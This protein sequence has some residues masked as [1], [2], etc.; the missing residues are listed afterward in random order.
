MEYMEKDLVLELLFHQFQKNNTI[1]LEL[2]TGDNHIVYTR[3]EGDSPKFFTNIA[4]VEVNLS[5]LSSE[6]TP[7]QESLLHNSTIIVYAEDNKRKE[8]L[9]DEELTFSPAYYKMYVELEKLFPEYTIEY[10][11][12]EVYQSLRFPYSWSVY[13][14]G[15]STRVFA[16]L[17]LKLPKVMFNF[18]NQ[19]LSDRY[20]IVSLPLE[21]N[22][23]KNRIRSTE[24][25]VGRNGEAE[26]HTEYYKTKLQEVVDMLVKE[27]VHYRVNYSNMVYL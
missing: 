19:S 1:V 7:Q 21:K 3:W 12:V 23:G 17:P 9:Y 16:V 18:N 20:L 26:V 6:R 5:P 25:P 4:G 14:L 27:P 11:N 2:S 10:H 15:D 13:S 8:I 22:K 24:F